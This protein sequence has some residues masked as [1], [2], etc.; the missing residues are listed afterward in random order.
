MIVRN[1]HVALLATAAAFVVTGA[2]AQT[3]YEGNGQVPQKFVVSG[4]AA[5]RLHDNISINADTAAFRPLAFY[6]TAGSVWGWCVWLSHT[7]Q[8]PQI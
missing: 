8:C 6:G 2:Q 7:C 4:K 1:L 5:D 3:T